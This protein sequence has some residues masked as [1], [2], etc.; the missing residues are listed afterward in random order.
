MRGRGAGERKTIKRQV[1]RD[2]EIHTYRQRMT[3]RNR[4]RGGGQRQIDGDRQR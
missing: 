1:G 3:I 4:E 2:K